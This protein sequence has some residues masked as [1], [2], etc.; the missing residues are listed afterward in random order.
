MKCCCFP[1][2]AAHAYHLNTLLEQLLKDAGLSVDWKETILPI[3]K[4]ISE[5][6]E[7]KRLDNFSFVV[8]RNYLLI[9]TPPPPKEGIN[10]SL[11]SSV[12]IPF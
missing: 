1:F 8:H 12:Q 9:N 4:I 11:A 6:V 3:V 5:Q 2:R 10:C 7:H